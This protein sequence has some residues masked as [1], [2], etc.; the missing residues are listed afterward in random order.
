MNK[1]H[2]YLSIRFNESH[3]NYYGVNELL[4][5]L[6]NEATKEDLKDEIRQLRKS[7]AIDIVGGLNGYLIKIIDE[8]KF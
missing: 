2:S 8:T 4:Y 6:R 3:W 7:G 5:D 1:V